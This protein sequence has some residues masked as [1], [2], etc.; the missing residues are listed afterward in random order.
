VQFVFSDSPTDAWWP[1]S[2][3]VYTARTINST[4]VCEA[5]KVT[6]GGDGSTADIQVESIGDVTVYETV[7]N[8]TTFFVAEDSTCADNVRC[9]VVQVF[10]ASN[11]DPWYYKC[12]VTMSNTFNDPS[13]VSFISDDMAQIAV[14]SIA[15]TG[16]VDASGETGEIYP[17]DSPWG[18]PLA[19]D[20]SAMGMTIASFGIG[21]IAGASIY[22]PFTWYNGSAPSQGVYL[23][24]GHPYP[25]YLILGL[26]CGCHFFFLI[27]VAFSAN[28]VMVGP[29]EA[30]SMALLLRPIADAL[31][32]V[33]GGKENKAFKDAKR[34]TMVK[35]E[36][37][38][39]GRWT[40]KMG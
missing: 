10:E 35:Y 21:A 40:M 12:N 37:A 17:Q 20:S 19:G 8:A 32:G 34:S 14:S 7:A 38:P 30:L 5:H 23:E 11:T 26:I 22:N 33:S 39:N 24:L 29:E 25:F 13:N 2:S 6:K 28:R 3:S 1:A 9:Q 18:I 31:D 16:F 15:Q 27:V 4:Y 36:K